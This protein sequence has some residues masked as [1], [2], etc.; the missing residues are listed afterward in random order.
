MQTGK[1]KKCF[2]YF[3]VKNFNKK[4]AFMQDHVISIKQVLPGKLTSIPLNR[5]SGHLKFQQAAI[6]YFCMRK[7]AT[8]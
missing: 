1:G 5:L 7:P 6:L 8:G 3:S 2:C 4:P